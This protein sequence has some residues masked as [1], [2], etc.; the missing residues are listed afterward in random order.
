[1]PMLAC[2]VC[3]EE[4]LERA[5]THSKTVCNPCWVKTGRDAVST[6]DPQSDEVTDQPVRSQ[7]DQA[8]QAEVGSYGLCLALGIIGILIGGFI[9]IDPTMEKSVPGL[10]TSTTMKVVNIHLLNVG[11]TL[12]IAGSIFLAAALRPRR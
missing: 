6:T 3:G 11:Q 1:M 9:L 5:F 7:K 4:Y 2:S 12:V 8:L 10:Y